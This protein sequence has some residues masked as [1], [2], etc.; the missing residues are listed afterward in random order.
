MIRR[1]F[2][3][4]IATILLHVTHT[5]YAAE[6]SNVAYSSLSALP[7]T[8]PS[9]R[10][11]YGS[12]KLQFIDVYNGPEEV[13]DNKVALI[14]IHGGCWLNAYDLNHARGF[15]KAL[16]DRGIDV[17]AVEYRRAGDEGGGWPGSRNDVISALK[18]LSTY[19]HDTSM[20]QRIALAGHSAGGHLALLASQDNTVTDNLPLHKVIGLA[21][22]TDITRYAQGT[23]SCQA[24]TKVFMGGMPS[25][26]EP[27]PSEY[28]QA[29]KN[30]QAAYREATPVIDTPTLPV[31]LLQGDADAIVPSLQANLAGATPR[32]IKAGGHFDWLHPE[33]LSFSAFYEEL[34]K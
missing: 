34:I 4:S 5:T 7:H 1:L 30:R 8:E 32:V 3:V 15:Y 33:T 10:L 13:N 2:L 22:I 11:T 12:D 17:Y 9:L 20:P 29:Q 25:V 28:S 31:I 26:I 16:S 23:N 6:L 24:A 21:A 14:F 18:Y 27:Q 19:W